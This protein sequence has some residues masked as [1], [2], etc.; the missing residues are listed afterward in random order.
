MT[1]PDGS[2]AALISNMAVELIVILALIVANG[3]FAMAETAIISARKA[4]LQQLADE[5]HTEAA[6][7]LALA[8]KPASFLAT[9]Q[10]GITLIGV[11]TGAVGGATLS[12]ELG[13]LLNRIPLLA[14]YSGAIAFVIIVGL[15]TYLSLVIGEL[16]PK[17][18]ALNNPERV[19]SASAGPMR[20]LSRIFAPL[21]HLLDL[22]T[23]LIL[24]ALGMRPSEE[25]S[26]TEDEI[27]ILVRQGTAAGTFEET[28]RQ[29]IEQ[30]LR[31]GDLSGAQMM[32]P[33]TDIAWI[34]TDSTFENVRALVAEHGYS[35][36]PV[37]RETLD[38][39]VGVV[40]VKDLYTQQARGAP[41]NL[42]A[43]VRPPLFLPETASALQIMET[44]RG[45]RSHIA[46]LIDEYGGLRGLI[47]IGDILE[48]LAGRSLSEG[49][50]DEPMVI[51]RKD[52]SWLL[53]GMLPIDRLPELL[54]I[55]FTEEDDES[56][57]NTLA[58]FMLAHLEH[59]P[60]SGEA[61]TAYEYR[62]EVVDM[63][64]RRIDKVLVTADP[65]GPAKD[66]R[67]VKGDSAAGG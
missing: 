27:R 8:N 51:R 64:G 48:S 28:E 66:E 31:F 62:F 20:T 63:D 39:V 57:F 19:A 55:R 11:L 22:S 34:S 45:Q 67:A 41:F 16:V 1:F 60:I 47:T 54:S 37:A 2:R 25:P 33:R 30:A 56:I 4:R 35:R 23:R 36:Y 44:L 17:A 42:E 12:D 52:G 61:F 18:L 38:N 29:I 46:F 49:E 3:Y 32:T 5:G 40:R 14:P 53:D 10:I 59:V 9:V 65:S 15:T 24:R 6:A 50:D 7:A 26:V 58:G 43:L 13:A 21:V